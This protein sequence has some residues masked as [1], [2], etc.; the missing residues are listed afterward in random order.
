M[1]YYEE[2][3]KEGRI[4]R[5]NALRQRLGNPRHVV[6]TVSSQGMRFL[7]FYIYGILFYELLHLPVGAQV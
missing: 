3:E 4:S 6:P 2:G 7:R 5:S 1:E